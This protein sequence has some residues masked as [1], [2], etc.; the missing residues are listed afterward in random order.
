MRDIR[1]SSLNDG[2]QTI[3]VSSAILF[4]SKYKV[5]CMKISFLPVL[6]SLIPNTIA[7]N[8]QRFLSLQEDVYNIRINRIRLIK[9]AHTNIVK[10][11]LI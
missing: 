8:S 7:N 6:I 2:L 5:S 9:S 4:L 1:N 11:G 3:P 10:V